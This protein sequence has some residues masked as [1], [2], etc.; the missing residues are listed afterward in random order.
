[1]ALVDVAVVEAVVVAR[2][3]HAGAAA[4]ALAAARMDL[5]RDTLAEPVFVD[6]RS[7]G[8][9]RAHIFMARREVLVEGQAALDRGGRAVVD[10]LEIGG[11]D[12]NRIDAHEHLGL[13]GHRHLLVD[14]LE[15]ARIADDPSLHGLGNREILARLDA[16][17]R[18]HAR[19]SYVEIVC[20]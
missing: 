1:V 9:H 19:S 3:V 14:E 4:L 7:E 18:I 16:G 2:G 11:A 17:G 12:R 5:D 13:G 20:F 6:A 10:D 8:D 15:L